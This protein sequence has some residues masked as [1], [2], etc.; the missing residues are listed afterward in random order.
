MHRWEAHQIRAVS[1][2]ANVT[3]LG[4]AKPKNVLKNV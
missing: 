4:A 3:F 2:D 1:S